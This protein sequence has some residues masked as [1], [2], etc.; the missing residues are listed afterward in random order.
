MGTIYQEF[1]KRL[2]EER[3]RLKLSQNDMGC[4]LHMTQ[5]HYCKAERGTRRFTYREMNSMGKMGLDV[6]YLITGYRCQ[7]PYKEFLER[8]TAK[9]LRCYLSLICSVIE[10][11]YINKSY[12]HQNELRQL[13][14]A[15]QLSM[16]PRERGTTLLYT[17][18]RSGKI[19]QI[20]MAEM[21]EVDVKK[22]RELENG[23]KEPDGEL[24]CLL[25]EKFMVPI[26]LIL[27]DSIASGLE[28]ELS[29]LL[30]LMKE[31]HR[32]AVFQTLKQLHEILA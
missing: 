14:E 8:C 16:M 7:E 32:E 22:L 17:L 12:R 27:D 15:I 23:K 28:S 21:L 19:S 24:M 3:L 11:A 31:E 4:F 18:R 5:S 30:E 29:Y 13:I 9:E 6:T 25:W 1:L 10:C 20:A 26:S 2:K